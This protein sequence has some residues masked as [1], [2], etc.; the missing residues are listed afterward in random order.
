MFT[1]DASSHRDQSAKM[2]REEEPVL[3]QLFDGE[4]RNPETDEQE[5]KEGRSKD[6]VQA[7]EP[8][9]T[10]RGYF[11]D[12]SNANYRDYGP[13]SSYGNI[14]PTRDQYDDNENEI[15]VVHN[16]HN[17]R[18]QVNQYQNHKQRQQ[19]Y[20]QFPQ[21]PIPVQTAKYR[22]SPDKFQNEGEYS[23][24]Y[25]PP[26]FNSHSYSGGGHPYEFDGPSQYRGQSQAFGTSNQYGGGDNGF[27]N[28]GGSSSYHSSPPHTYHHHTATE[29][30]HLTDR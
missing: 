1:L 21:D 5:E 16:S 25:N 18:P 22:S 13:S 7:S 14:L 19:Q 28:G 12:E 10:P 3:H 20:Q 4:N 15:D 17:P 6:I 23:R 30:S 2:K 8:D 9:K 11:N 26:S 29:G 24:P 27:N